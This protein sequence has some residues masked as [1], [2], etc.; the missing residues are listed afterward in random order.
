M[1]RRI[2]VHGLF[3]STF[4]LVVACSSNDDAA[5]TSSSGG[6]GASSSSSSSSGGGS[7]GGFKSCPDSSQASCTEAELEPYNR[8][9]LDECEAGFKKCYGDGFMSGNFGGPCGTFMAC[10]QKCGCGD[11][12][13]FATC[14]PDDACQSCVQETGTCG[15]SCTEP[16][17]ASA[18]TS[19]SGG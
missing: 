5:S 11:T 10:V 15:E 13:C 3:A 1:T 8:C 2:Y 4:A 18:G 6:G 9:L 17:C 7:S 16:A 19:S 12:E 14:T